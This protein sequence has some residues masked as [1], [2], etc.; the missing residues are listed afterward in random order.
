MGGPFHCC[1][2]L[3]VLIP[4][5]RYV[6][7]STSG[8]TQLELPLCPQISTETRGWKAVEA[9]CHVFDSMEGLDEQLLNMKAHNARLKA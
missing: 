2:G 3:P 1:F 9:L 8:D 7:I 6:Q 5:C 4:W